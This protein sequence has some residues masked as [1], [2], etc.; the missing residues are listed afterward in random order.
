[1][2]TPCVYILSSVSK[3]LYIGVTSDLEARLWQHKNK[4][5]SGF[6]SKYDVTI[7]VHVELLPDMR[8]AIEREKQIKKWRR[9]K[10]LELIRTS[11]PHW[12][13]LSAGWGLG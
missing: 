6:S 12:E 13:D 11:N 8:Q 10:K 3:V 1:M 5:Y 7:L 9:E 2:K 4:T